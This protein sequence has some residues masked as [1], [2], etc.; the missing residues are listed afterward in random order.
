MRVICPHCRQSVA[1]P[2]A[3]AGTPTPCPLCG[4]LFTPPALTGAAI[5][6]APP[7]VVKEPNPPA[8]FP[9]RE[10]G[11]SSKDPLGSSP[12]FPLREGGAGGLG[13]AKTAGGLGSSSTPW[14]HLTLR[15]EAAHWTAPVALVV[16]LVLTFFTWVEAAPNGTVVY[17]ET[18]WQAATGSFSTTDPVADA[19]L[20]GEQDFPVNKHWSV[21]LLFYLILLVVAA[22]AA[23]ADRVLARNQTAM[24]DVFR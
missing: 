9:L 11:E 20:E 16:A 15:R 8:P 4:Q 23:V 21:A 6:A 24:P 3:A 17:T 18:A 5:D 22:V 10:G 12:P 2:D 7:P 19:V 13:S 1:L 14:F